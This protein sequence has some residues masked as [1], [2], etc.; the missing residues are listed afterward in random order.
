MGLQSAVKS[1]ALS[2]QGFTKPKYT[3]YEQ[4]VTKDYKAILFQTFL[5]IFF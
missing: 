1:K 5:Q 3:H 2:L 4:W